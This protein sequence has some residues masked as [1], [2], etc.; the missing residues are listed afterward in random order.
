MPNF[1]GNEQEASLLKLLDTMDQDAVGRELEVDGIDCFHE[2]S[3]SRPSFIVKLTFSD[4]DV[5]FIERLSEKHQSAVE[6]T[7]EG[8]LHFQPVEAHVTLFK[9]GDDEG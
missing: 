7:P 2:L 9:T 8:S 1:Q 4:E 5:Q 6:R 3:D